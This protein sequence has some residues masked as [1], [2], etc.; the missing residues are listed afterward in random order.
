MANNEI[1]IKREQISV[2]SGRDEEVTTRRVF[3]CEKSSFATAERICDSAK[4]SSHFLSLAS[5]PFALNSTPSSP[6]LA[7]LLFFVSTAKKKFFCEH[8]EL[9]S[10]QFLR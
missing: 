8:R 5:F 7:S 9:F 2:V 1:G 6:Q 3:I 4:T 10:L